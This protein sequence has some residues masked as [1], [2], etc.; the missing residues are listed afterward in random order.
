[1]LNNQNVDPEK[2]KSA[3]TKKTK[4]IMP[5]HLSGRMAQMDKIFLSQKKIILK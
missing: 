2:I 4:A 1:M 5:V 3:I